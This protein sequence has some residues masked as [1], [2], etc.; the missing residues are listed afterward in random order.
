[1]ETT[2]MVLEITGQKSHSLHIRYQ[3]KGKAEGN[4][5]I[6]LYHIIPFTSL[7]HLPNTSLIP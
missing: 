6:I 2:F 5:F 4:V 1:M 7:Y 3:V